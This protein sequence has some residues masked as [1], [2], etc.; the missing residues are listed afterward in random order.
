VLDLVGFREAA[1]GC[2]LVVTGEGTVDASSAEGKATGAVV[3][4]SR[5]LGLRCVVF[6]GLVEEPFAG[7]ETR[8]L[9][10]RPDQA[11]EDLVELGESLGLELAGRRSSRR[12][13]A[14]GARAPRSGLARCRA[15]RGRTRRAPR[16]AAT[17]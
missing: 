13:R 14:C 15:G 12:R 8:A 10:G 4:A 3:A 5:S 6:G 2:D 11:A 16:R 7:V 9:S 1:A 17:A